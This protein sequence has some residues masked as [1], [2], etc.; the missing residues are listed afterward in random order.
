M[1]STPRRPA[2][3]ARR[4]VGRLAALAATA[5]LTLTGCAGDETA[6]TEPSTTLDPRLLE[7]AR[8]GGACDEQ[9]AVLQGGQVTFEQ[10]QSA[11]NQTAACMREA[12]IEVIDDTVTQ[13]RGFPEI[14]YSFASSS[15]GRTDEQT[16]AI[17]DECMATHSLYVEQAYLTAPG[18]LEQ[19]EAAFAP[20]RDPIMTCVR[21]NGG[22]LPDDAPAGDILVAAASVE[23]QTGISCTGQSGYG[24]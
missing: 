7:S 12:G 15:A 22:E 23:V 8:E 2:G 11:V 17:A 9:L 4:P 5:L 21:E 6:A 19:Q 16:L 20:Y 10:Y 1:S 13:P 3:P 24:G 18:T 14:L